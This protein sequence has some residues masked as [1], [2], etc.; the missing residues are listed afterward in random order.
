MRRWILGLLAVGLTVTGLAAPAGASGNT[1]N[2][3]VDRSGGGFDSSLADF[4]VLNAAIDTA[5]L[6]GA[7][8]DPSAKLTVFAPRD[9][10]FVRLAKDLGFAGGDEAAAWDYLV[11]ALTGLGG[12]DP[13]PVLTDV[14]L[15]HVAPWQLFSDQVLARKQINTLLGANIGVRS[16][17]I[18]K[19]LE[20]D[21][22]NARIIAVDIRA[23]NGVAHVIDR[24]LLPVDL[25]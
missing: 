6:D 10:A 22:P 2:D 23:A 13:I 21:I 15:Y 19:D 16:P 3:I 9:S 25:P 17:N 5:G 11:G 7:L 24:V 18:L 1:L 8:G 4:D 14:L 20:P 12:G